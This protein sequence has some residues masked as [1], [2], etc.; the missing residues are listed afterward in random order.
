MFTKLTRV[1]LAAALLC[2]AVGCQNQTGQS[3]AVIAPASSATPDATIAA[4]IKSLRTNN[5][6]A[7]LDT[8]LPAPVLA[9]AKADWSKDFNQGSISDEDRKKFADLVTKLTAPDAETKLYTEVEPQLKQFDQ[10]MAQQMPMMIAM[11]QGF[12]Q[13]AVQQ[14]KDLDEQQKKQTLDAMNAIAKW[15]GTVKFT[16]PALVKQVI[17]VTCKTA[18]DLNLKTLDEM[19]AMS[20]D[21][22]TQKAGIAIGGLKKALDVYGFSI[23]QALDST[24]VEVLSMEGD[25]AKVK[26]NYSLLNAPLSTEGD[27]VKLDGKWY[28][29]QA[30]DQWTK[31]QQVSA[32]AAAA[33]PT[34]APDSNDEDGDGDD[35]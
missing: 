15:A 3:T 17:A 20:F 26:I 10:Q 33:S 19:R 25:K 4:T 1:S 30:V 23:D 14:N 28:G 6:G 18:R 21:Q 32:P 35:Q 22:A 11:G 27:M 24:K 34:A 31:S 7:F 5:I 13:N 2:G 12:I 8:A 29:K 9:K 16:D